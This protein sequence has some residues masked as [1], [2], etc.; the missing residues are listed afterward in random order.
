MK[1]AIKTLHD[2]QDLGAA[3]ILAIK[4]PEGLFTGPNA[5]RDEYL[6]LS[7]LW[8]PDKNPG[9]DPK[10]FAHIVSL[11]DCAKDKI[12]KGEWEI[13][14][15]FWA[16]AKDGRQY[17]IRFRRKRDFEL[18]DVF[19]GGASVVYSIKKE[20]FDLFDAMYKTIQG[21]KFSSPAMKEEIGDYLPKDLRVLETPD[22]RILIASKPVDVFSLRDV[23]SFHGGRMP[24]VHVAWIMSRLYN[25]ACYLKYAKI[26]HNDI[27][28]DSVFISPALHTAY[29]LGGWWYSVPEGEKMKALP[30]RSARLI[31]A[32]ILAEKLGDSR[33]DAE[34]IKATGRELLGDVFG[35]KLINDK[36]IPKP[37]FNWLMMPGSDNPFRDYETWMNTVLVE[38]FGK[39]RFV[40]LK[41][42]A[43]Q[44][45]NT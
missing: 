31:P 40:E 22:R 37:M 45:Y 10:V 21:F 42:D 4:T 17:Q 43:N 36:S 41:L 28:P 29:L 9:E 23:L 2:M 27:S 19:I 12:A 8:H 11:W 25:L 6:I 30:S 5:A 18:G 35:T 24:A 26:T 13:P 34:L 32:K 39:R 33:L 16:I 7:K 38:S 20:A 1:S 44:I 15:I 3:D 14:G